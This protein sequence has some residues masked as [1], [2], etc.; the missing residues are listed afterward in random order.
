MAVWLVRAGSAGEFEDKFISERRV[1][2]TWDGLNVDLSTLKN[3][4]QVQAELSLR[5]P[6]IEAENAAKLEQP[7]LA[8]CSAYAG[9]RLDRTA[10]QNPA[11]G[12][13]RQTCRGLS[14]LQRWP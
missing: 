5:L 8:L 11:G 14:F 12:L 2:V 3:R 9:W 1:Y 7:D 4:E 10:A 6:R 13:Y